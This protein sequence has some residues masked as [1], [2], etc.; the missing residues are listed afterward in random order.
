MLIKIMDF[1]MTLLNML[2]YNIL[3]FIYFFSIICYL[4]FSIVNNTTVRT[5]TTEFLFF[6]TVCTVYIFFC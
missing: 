4:L 1:N 2:T 5:D 3:L 6:T